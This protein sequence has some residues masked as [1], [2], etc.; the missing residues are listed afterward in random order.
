MKRA[1]AIRHV[2]FEDIGVFGPVLT[3]RGYHVAYADAGLDDLSAIEEGA[4]D[5]LVILGAPIGAYEESLYPFLEH[6]IRLIQRRLASGR[7]M[8][9]ICLG[10]QLMARAMGAAV[11][12]GPA[13]E[14]GWAPVA[15]TEA[16]RASPLRHLGAEPVLHW[17]GDMFELPAGA[18]RLAATA[19]CPNQAFAYGRSVLGIQFHPEVA[20]DRFEPW[21]I[22]HAA[23][24]ASAGLSPVQLRA[25]TAAH[26]RGSAIRGRLLIEE[27]LAAL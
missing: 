25:D 19:I 4:I 18:E 3:E 21:L 11:R 22:G 2:H 26:G 14:I 7:P 17:H 6:E 12:P 16:G 13:K 20:Y 8:L 5:L 27:W 23:E 24:I 10:A 1:L 15:L 9:G